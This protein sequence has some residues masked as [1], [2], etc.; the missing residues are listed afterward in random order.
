M[1]CL[2]T[3]RWRADLCNLWHR[4]VLLFALMWMEC[5]M[6]LAKLTC[7]AWK[8]ST[9]ALQAM[10]RYTQMQLLRF[11][12]FIPLLRL[13]SMQESFVLTAH[14]DLHPD[15]A[16]V[17]CSG[18]GWVFHDAGIS[19]STLITHCRAAGYLHPSCEEL[20]GHFLHHG[21]SG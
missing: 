16:F 12:N 4:H 6:L 9:S 2:P 20:K 17:P 8:I 10:V 18:I 15:H 3:Q 14:S 7:N 11:G 21:G 1:H 19:S 13:S 5:W